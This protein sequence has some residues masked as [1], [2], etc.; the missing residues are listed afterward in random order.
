MDV[1]NADI[2][3]VT[4][5][6]GSYLIDFQFTAE[7]TAVVASALQ[8]VGFRWIE[9]GHG[10]GLNASSTISPA[11]A[12]T[13][14]EYLEAAGSVLD[15]ARWGMFFIPGIARLDDLRL[16][17]R[18]GMK[19]VRIGT[20]VTQSGDAR[21]AIELAKD[22]GLFVSYNAMKS[23]AVP[24][25][26]FAAIAADVHSWGADAVCLVDSAG[27]FDPETVAGYLRATRSETG[28][29]LGFH[30]HDNLSMA[31]ANSLRAIEE[32]AVLVDSSLQGMGRSA[33]NAITE[34]L[35][36]IAQQ[37]GLMKHIDLKSAMDVGHAL[38]QPLLG[39]RGVDPLAVTAGLA[40]F[41]SSFMP[42]VASYA[43][44]H[45]VDV[46]DLIVRLC[47]EDQVSAPD[48][49]LEELSRDVASQKLARTIHIPAY[50][51]S[52]PAGSG[53]DSLRSLA[54]ELHSG[55]L[56]RGK[57]AALNVVRTTAPLDSFS[58]SG[59]IHQSA[60]HVIGVVTVATQAQWE[61]VVRAA[62][63]AVDV[64]F[65]DVDRTPGFDEKQTVVRKSRVL[66]Y[67]DSR[68]WVDA[69]EDQVVRI[70]GEWLEGT[71]ITILGDSAKSR[72][73]A[74]RLAERG[75]AVTSGPAQTAEAKAVIVWPE[76]GAQHGPDDLAS[77]AEGTYVLDAAIGGLSP[78]AQELA[79]NRGAQLLRVD[80]WPQLS[81]A[82][83]AAHESS[84]VAES[85]LGWGQVAGVSVVSGGAVGRA[86]DI[87]LD[88]VHE[89]TRIIGIADGRGGIRFES[90]SAEDAERI[91]LVREDIYRRLLE[92][93][94]ALGQ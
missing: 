19:F 37:R 31:V 30:G 24:P 9:V 41:H 81:A 68:V 49:L 14:E 45:H 85:A 63:G 39:R 33:G 67:R 42:K 35:V 43:R 91:R 79:R 53:A 55:A 20:N 61:E 64:L 52:R 1:A 84:R 29:A 70:L 15:R 44:K 62:D 90:S 23:Y 78:A 77:V 51:R 83:E 13:D 56:K 58:V 69:V 57:F 65:L 32:G 87:V 88:S 73:L 93:R 12:A 7:D 66:T 28:A 27:S 6:D 48:D 76:R 80:V 10:A 92:P 16:A 3:E 94:F 82:L 34:V 36:G 38:I 4:L 21:A 22:L 72:R 75:A 26:A 17:A 60:A 11:A 47:Q 18:Y 46:R 5:R 59:N 8:S 89:P 40:R 2:L 86:G 54:A 50:S 71:P 74:V 25:E